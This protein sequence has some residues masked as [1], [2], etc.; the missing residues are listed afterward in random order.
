MI[1]IPVIADR[2]SYL[3]TICIWQA[4]NGEGAMS[5]PCNASKYR[6]IT[7]EVHRCFKKELET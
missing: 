5:F 2:L 3:M 7:I 1:R 6:A 4:A